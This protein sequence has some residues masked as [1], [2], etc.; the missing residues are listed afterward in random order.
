LKIVAVVVVVV[1]VVVV[2][3]GIKT[4]FLFNKKVSTILT[5]Y[6]PMA[7]DEVLRVVPEQELLQASL[8]L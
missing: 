6:Q 7:E 4:F 2:A 1:V 3:I 8:P 5:R